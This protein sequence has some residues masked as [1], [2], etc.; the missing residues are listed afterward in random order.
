MSFF[1]SFFRN[2][3][4][5]Q[6][7]IELKNDVIISGELHSIDQFLNIKLNNISVDPEKYPQLV[8]LKNM[9]I[10]GSVVRYIMLDPKDIDVDA[11][12]DSSRKF[13]NKK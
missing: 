9:Y 4:G 11:L 6:V 13:L 5:C 8:C 10:R 3:V 7:A 12:Q 2:L 1:Y